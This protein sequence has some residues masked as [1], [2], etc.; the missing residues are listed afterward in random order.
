MG[1]LEFWRDLAVIILAIMNLIWLVVMIAI[2]LLIYKKV[3]PLLTSATT[4]VNNIQGTTTFIAETTVS[5][6][7]R[8]LSFVSGMKAAARTVGSMGKSKGGR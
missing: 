6:I 4:A 3:G 2:G 7:I 1:S 5:P 8:V